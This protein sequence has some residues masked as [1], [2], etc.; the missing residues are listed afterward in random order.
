MTAVFSAFEYAARMFD[1][2]RRR[3]RNPGHLAKRL[4]TKNY[5]SPAL[6]LIDQEL[7]DLID[8]AADHDALMV[9]L[10]PQE[11]KSQKVS[12]RF[13]EWLLDHDP[14]VRIAIASYGEELAV[15]WGRDIKQ[16][17]E[18]NPCH[19]TEQ[20]GDCEADCGGLHI[21]IRRDSSAAGRWE[22]PAGGGVYCVGIG[23]P[24]TGRPVDVLERALIID[25]PV[26]DRAAAESSKIRDSTWDWWE[27]V[28]L[29][30]LAPGARTV[31]IQCM[32]GDTPVMMGDGTGRP[33]RD[34]RPGDTVATYENG[35]L[36]TSTVRNWANQGP[37]SV[38]MIRMKSGAVV[39][40]N[41]RHPFLTVQDGAETWRRTDTLR[42]GSLIRRVTRGNGAESP[43]PATSPRESQAVTARAC[44]CPATT[45][46]AGQ[47]GT[48][49]RQSPPRIAEPLTSSTA[50][51]SPQLSMTGCSQSRTASALS[52]SAP[53]ASLPIGSGRSASITT[54][55]PGGYAA[56]SATTATLLSATVTASRSSTQPLS[57]YGTGT[58]EIAEVA[59]CGTEDVF[60]LQI[61]RTENFVANGLISHNTRWHQDDLAGRILSRPSPLR[62]KVLSIPAIAVNDDPLGRLPGE[63]LPSVRRREPG[64]FRRLAATMSRYVFSGVYQQTPTAAEGNFFRRPTFRYWRDMPAWHDGRE[65]ID[66]EGT[67]VTLADTWRFITMDFAASSRSSADFTVASCWAITNMGDLVLLDRVRARVPDHEH[68]ALCAPLIE[69][70]GVTQVYVEQN[71][72]SK[73]FVADARDHGTPVAPLLADTDKVTRAI[74][75]AGRI[76]SGK[77]WFPAVTSGC[78]C[79]EC[80]D[81][82][83]LDEWCD[84]LAI[85]PEGTHDDQVDTLA[86]AARVAVAEWTP[87]PTP[88]RPGFS[89]HERAVAA[90]HDSATGD[91]RRDLDIMNLPY[92]T[93]A[94]RRGR[95]APGGTVP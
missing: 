1:P 84:E 24:L 37:D 76:H 70:W 54:T 20:H 12:R 60:D 75:A 63:E 28:A 43:A 46:S 62:W 52:A 92:L 56:C 33:L 86:Y 42:P 5:S 59:P 55:T 41:A 74:P 69:R 29:T 71:W 81:G 2:K 49:H 82:D 72:W 25:D 90:A 51:G 19:S 45:S 18:H 73:T 66:L 47:T 16:D 68:F 35:Q 67:A 85:F 83:W 36:T 44:A 50:T 7:T 39:K 4:D 21:P 38:Y 79:G 31:L 94:G 57:T 58:D 13:P 15:R 80:K 88:A 64:Y 32:T 61:D 30:R 78:P 9:F 93:K 53:T 22:T 26:K 65:R 89:P 40:A 34:V 23:G 95:D 3:Y 77:V 11:G 27:S 87:A 17:V 91:G 48:V 8:P 14:S 10:P 6:D